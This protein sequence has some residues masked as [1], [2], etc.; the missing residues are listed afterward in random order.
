MN[1]RFER[2]DSASNRQFRY[3]YWNKNADSHSSFKSALKT[4]LF[5][6][7]CFELYKTLH[8]F[9]LFKFILNQ[10]MRL[11]FNFIIDCYY[12]NHFYL[13][14]MTCKRIEIFWM[15]SWKLYY[16]Y[17]YKVNS[18]TTK[19]LN[20][21]QYAMESDKVCLKIPRF[22]RIKWKNGIYLNNSNGGFFQF[23]R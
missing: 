15:R 11:F 16:C 20:R 3:R 23:L 14:L 18:W 13:L 8:R 4:S 10:F 12:H 1:W 19:I 9:L 21:P 5:R 17:Y 6:K 7:S 22:I 2:N